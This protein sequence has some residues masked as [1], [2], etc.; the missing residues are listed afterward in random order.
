MNKINFYQMGIEQVVDHFKTNIR[1]GLTSK[2]SHSY[3]KEYGPNQLPNKSRTTAFRVLINQFLSPLMLILLVAVVAS[4][5]IK[6]LGDAIVIGIAVLINVVLGFIQEWKAEKAAEKL[7]TFEVD[8][9][10]VRRD[11]QTISIETKNLVPGDIVFL[12]AGNK[13]PAD[14]RLVRVVDFQVQEALLTGESATSSKHTEQLEGKVPVGDRE[15]MAFMGTFV[16]H[17]RAE[18]IV[19]KTGMSTQ[20]GEIARLVL[21]SKDKP[22][23]IQIQLKRFSWLLGLMMLFVT[24]AIFVVGFLRNFNFKEIISISIALAVAAV[25]EGLLVG[26]TIVLAIGMQRMLKRKALVKKLIAA[27]TLGSVSVICT[28]K[29][30]TLTKGQLSVV[31]IITPNSDFNI[32]DR[33]GDEVYDLLVMAVLN[34][35]ASVYMKSGSRVGQ[36]TEVA[37]MES[38]LNA[39]IDVSQKK[40]IF[41]RIREIPFSSDLKYMAT[42]HHGEKNERLIV[43]G[44]PEVVF[45]MCSVNAEDKKKFEHFANEMSEEGLRILSFAFLDKDKINIEN[46]IKHLTFAGLV[47]MQ[48]ALRE[49]AF[50]TVKS[51]ESAGIKTVVVTG[52]H[53][54]TAVNIAKSAG[55]DV[56]EDGVMTGM[57]LDETSDA[58]LAEKIENI[59]VFAR[60][61]PKDKVRI[62][63]AW[64][65]HD[66]CVAMTGDGVNDA[67]A[68]KAADIGIALGS[69]SDLTHEIAD[70]VLLDDNLSVVAAAVRE[71]RI[72]FDNIRKVV[73]YLLVDSFSEVVLIGAAVLIGLPSPLS[74]IQILWI[75]L[76][77]DGFPDMALTMEPAEPGIM[78]Q[79]PRHKN[80]PIV[81]K[82]MKVMIFLIGIITDIGLFAIYLIFRKMQFD[83]LHLRT[84]IFT[85]LAVDSLLYVFSVRSMKSSIFRVNPFRN[86]WLN[87]AV[88]LGFLVQLAAI[89]VPSL[90][91][92]FSTV[93]LSFLEWGIILALSL[94]KITCIELTKDWFLRRKSKKLLKY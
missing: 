13:V 88:I 57:Q 70:M 28:D 67:P 78:K 63:K 90:Q 86:K 1:S 81:N 47:G 54:K 50:D 76:V 10:Q 35:N 43:K 17:G 4:I 39:N 27:E 64:Q 89:Y 40:S 11:G 3:L 16:L 21:V 92:L 55:V 94:I 14:V 58:Q 26:V 62:I 31:K 73:V 72:I 52:D 53:T 61:E 91:C 23:P 29:T 38:A 51:L 15:N 66:K 6:E 44:A 74:A 2:A 48:D 80:E 68:L 25:P 71:G 33:I 41:K 69:G 34:N 5:I 36:P 19:V 8:R 85:A 42:V 22:T 93:S 18:G 60:V 65:S 37:L 83:L 46:D 56:R 9:C 77:S 87:F 32:G 45:D 24:T 84:I 30:G 59:D 82:E 75:N 79:K 20:L 49:T 7:R 12:S